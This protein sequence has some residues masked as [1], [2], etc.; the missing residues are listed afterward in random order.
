VNFKIIASK[1]RNFKLILKILGAILKNLV[2]KDLWCP[3]IQYKTLSDDA[4]NNGNKQDPDI[5]II[6]CDAD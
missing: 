3:A 1:E 2:A 6:S 4:H 5:V